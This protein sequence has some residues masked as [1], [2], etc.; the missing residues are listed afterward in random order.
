MDVL[1]F[2]FANNPQEPLDGLKRED[3]G[4]NRLIEP[5]AAN[6]NFRNVRDSFATLEFVADKLRTYRK[7]LVLFHYSGHAGSD[8]LGLEDGS[9]YASGIAEL[10]AACPRLQVVVL[11]ACATQG[12][13]DRLHQKGIP[14][15]VATYRAVEDAQAVAFALQFYSSLAQLESLESAFKAACGFVQAKDNGL[16]T[17]KTTRG[18][19][20]RQKSTG[21]VCWALLLAPH[22]ENVSGWKIIGAIPAAEFIK[23]TRASIAAGKTDESIRE[24]L[25]FTQN[26]HPDLH[27]ETVQL[28]E[29]WKQLAR[30]NR[31]GTISNAD[32][33]LE[34][35]QIV[36]RLLNTLQQLEEDSK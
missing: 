16:E 3:A 29:Q 9:A 21:E 1:Y 31:T 2:A 7:E 8:M 13:V 6:G 27:T 34:Q 18:L 20:L 5:M 14:A 32:A 15:V 10:L 22:S 24:V 26:D 25:A 11:N 35:R 19:A 30:K 33:G 28:S 4:I 36:F 23:K 17:E 12:Q